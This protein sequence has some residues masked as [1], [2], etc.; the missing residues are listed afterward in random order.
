MSDHEAGRGA[1]ELTERMSRPREEGDPPS[2][3]EGISADQAAFRPIIRPKKLLRGF[4]VDQSS[5]ML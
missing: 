1:G 3:R 2:C 4:F 5:K